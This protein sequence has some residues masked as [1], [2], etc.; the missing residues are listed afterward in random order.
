MSENRWKVVDRPLIQPF[1][2]E[3]L[4]YDMIQRHFRMFVL[5]M[6][7]NSTMRKK[8]ACRD[9]D[10]HNDRRMNGKIP[11]RET[12]KQTKMN[13]VKATIMRL[14]NWQHGLVFLETSLSVKCIAIMHWGTPRFPSHQRKRASP[15]IL[16]R[17]FIQKKDRWTANASRHRISI[18]FSHQTWKCV[19]KL[20]ST[21]IGNIRYCSKASCRLSFCSNLVG[22][23]GFALADVFWQSL[24]SLPSYERNHR[25]GVRNEFQSTIIH[26]HHCETELS[27]TIKYC[28]I[29]YSGTLKIGWV[30]GT[31]VR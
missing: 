15:Q 19:S 22:W 25:H 14:W 16:P 28:T 31:I 4:A 30:Q 2:C 9:Q 20:W 1:Y 24:F 27:S 10:S 23:S 21:K 8:N 29:Q 18:V 17:I 5:A 6:R 13:S 7:S 26:N 11:F 12:N 3:N